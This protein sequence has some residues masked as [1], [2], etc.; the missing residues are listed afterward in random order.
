M[1]KAR[2]SDRPPG[3]ILG[4]DQVDDL[5]RGVL[6][7]TREVWVLTDRLCVLEQVLESQGIPTAQIDTF[8]PDQALQD[9][10]AARRKDMIDT[11]MRAMGLETP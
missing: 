8:Q 3:R 2:P 11:V 5:A 4:S 7:L 1:S 10:L 9:K 6:A